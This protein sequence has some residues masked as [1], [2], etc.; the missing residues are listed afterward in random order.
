MTFQDVSYGSSVFDTSV[1]WLGGGGNI[2]IGRSSASPVKGDYMVAVL[3]FKSV[4]TSGTGAVSVLGTSSLANEGTP[5]V[6]QYGSA[7]INF[8]QAEAPKPAATPQAS[9]IVTNL[10]KRVALY[11][12][13]ITPPVLSDIRT[14]Q[15]A[16]NSQTIIWTTNEP[17]NS[18]VV[19]GVDGSYGLSAF[20]ATLTTSHKLTLNSAFLLPNMLFHYSIVSVDA[21]GNSVTSTDLLFTTKSVSYTVTV[22]DKDGK[23]LPGASVTLNGQT[24]YT[25]EN[26]KATLTSSAGNQAVSIAYHD[27]NMSKAV[28]ISTDKM[29]QFD[30]FQLATQRVIFDG[31]YII[32]P[33]VL[34][35]GIVL[36]LA[37]R[38]HLIKYP[39]AILRRGKTRFLNMPISKMQMEFGD[40]NPA[41]NPYQ[42]KR[43]F[44]FWA[45][46]NFFVRLV[47]RPSSK[48]RKKIAEEVKTAGDSKKPGPRSKS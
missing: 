8:G 6:A 17:S 16:A 23:P 11:A 36:G 31:S 14:E 2:R 48:V 10:S 42:L 24:M 35:L 32:Y 47:Q 1:E 38:A 30:S 43:L 44:S 20:D 29:Q 13:D 45:I 22:R 28:T 18:K 5:V 12:I 27:V 25:N 3:T 9:N 39:L 41:H 37:S 26:G 7:S 34:L 15:T 21:S 40:I 4:V 33:L 19:Y 46:E